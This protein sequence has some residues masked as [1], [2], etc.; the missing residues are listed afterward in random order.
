MLLT[1]EKQRQ[2]TRLSALRLRPRRRTH[3][4]AIDHHGVTCSHP[5]HSRVTHRSAQTRVASW[6]RSEASRSTGSQ[7]RVIDEVCKFVTSVVARSNTSRLLRFVR[8]ARESSIAEAQHG[9]LPRCLGENA[10]ASA[11]VAPAHLYNQPSTVMHSTTITLLQ[12]VASSHL[13]RVRS[14]SGSTP[15][16]QIHSLLSAC[17]NVTPGNR[18]VTRGAPD[19]KS[20]LSR[21]MKFKIDSNLGCEATR[22][23]NALR[24]A[25]K[26]DTK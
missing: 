7:V 17:V 2:R 1:A 24:I 10:D 4:D 26:R 19:V 9:D 14:S 13:T 21:E 11:R 3:V 12:S 23:W 8:V 15:Q 16:K 25:C 5:L 20:S 6:H 18:S 22:R